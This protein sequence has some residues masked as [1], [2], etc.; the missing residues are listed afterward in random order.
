MAERPT[1]ALR[2][3]L[4]LKRRIEN[5]ARRDNTP[6][7]TVLNQLIAMA[8]DAREEW[9]PKELPKLEVK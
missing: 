8:I 2:I 4:D 1:I 9:Q 3:N 7:S 6:V 5:I